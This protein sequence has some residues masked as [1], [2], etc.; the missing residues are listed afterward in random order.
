[1][2]KRDKV[3]DKVN[4]CPLGHRCD[5]CNWYRPLYIK[6]VSDEP[7]EEWDCA[8]P[9]VMILTGELKDSLLGVQQAVEHR[10][11]ESIKRQDALLQLAAHRRLANDTRATD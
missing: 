3:K 11:N 4:G 5:N 2:E 7:I 8:I 1:M 10:G 9:H 6:R